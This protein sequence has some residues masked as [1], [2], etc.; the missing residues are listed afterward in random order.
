M[1]TKVYFRSDFYLLVARVRRRGDR[2][3]S[4][5]DNVMV[6]IWQIWRDKEFLSLINGKFEWE[7]PPNI[8]ITMKP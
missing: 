6:S 8:L 7:S 5:L 1:E 2:P 4:S 3:P